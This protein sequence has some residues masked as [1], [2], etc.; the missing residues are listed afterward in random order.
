MSW[1]TFGLLLSQPEKRQRFWR[2]KA[3]LLALALLSAW[4]L[5]ALCWWIVYLPA[6]H[7]FI[8]NHGTFA[9]MVAGSGLL[10]LLAFSGG[11]WSTLL[12]RDVTT[13]FFA[14]VLAPVAILSA[15]MIWLW[16]G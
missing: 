10:T 11:L 7:W 3:G 16:A 4:A 6:D 14:A 1:G 8:I 12:L 2:I 9:Q 5:F 13:A 15:M